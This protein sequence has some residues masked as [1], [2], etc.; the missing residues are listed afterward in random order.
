MPQTCSVSLYQWSW[1]RTS[2]SEV[3]NVSLDGSQRMVDRLKPINELE[4]LSKRIWHYPNYYTEN[5]LTTLKL[6][7]IRQ[8]PH[9][10]RVIYNKGI[11]KIYNKSMFFTD[12]IW[13][14]NKISSDSFISSFKC[15]VN[16]SYDLYRI[17]WWFCYNYNQTVVES[18][19]MYIKF[20]VFF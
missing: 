14:T 4:R 6:Y 11:R 20:N 2:V 19:F 17:L 12:C 3:S 7:L 5:L 1:T 15:L 9:I 10:R 18:L 16:C 8:T 13:K